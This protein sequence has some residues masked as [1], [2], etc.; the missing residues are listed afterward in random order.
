MTTYQKIQ[1]I[2]TETYGDNG[3]TRA[4]I[5]YLAERIEADQ[6]DPR[7]REHAVMCI[8]WDCFPG[9]T[10]AAKTAQRIEDALA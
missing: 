10:T 3:W 6:W 9:G 1:D 2:L 5:A 4:C 7:G 8:L